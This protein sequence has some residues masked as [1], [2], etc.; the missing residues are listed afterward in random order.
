VHLRLVKLHT[1]TSTNSYLKEWIQQ[2]TPENFL[3]I[4][5]KE[6]TQGRG[7]RGHLWHSEANKNLIFS[8]LL[9]INQFNIDRQFELNQAISLGIVVV[10]KKYI[11]TVQIK[12]PND[13]MAGD[14][15]IGGILIE[16]TVKS[17]L[18]KHSIIGIGLNINQ[19]HFP[20]HIPNANSLKN[21]AHKNFDLD[22]LLQEILNSIASFVALF[23]KN[24]KK[25]LQKEYLKNLYL[26][27]KKSY[28]RDSNQNKFEGVI[29]GIGT[30]GKLQIELKSKKIVE[31][32]FKELTFIYP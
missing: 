21:I 24:S 1:T 16:N 3:V 8:I 23:D 11:P 32:G 17:T 10:L 12:W 14:Y 31:F 26:W 4:T 2:N 5:T 27:H 13:I 30:T 18:I 28:F 15:K 25:Y 7:Q 6:Q 29:I 22:I 9:K 20:A 19:T